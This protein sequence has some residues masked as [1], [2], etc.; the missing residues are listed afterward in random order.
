MG[1]VT[2]ERFIE[3][4]V[5]SGAD[6]V[7]LDLEDS[8][9]LNMK[10]EAR[11]VLPKAV[12]M[13]REGGSD[14]IVRINRPL[15]MAVPDMEAAV[16]PGVDALMLPKCGNP[17]HVR[18]LAEVVTELEN[19][20]RL[21]AGSVRFVVLIE[22]AAAFGQMESIA[23]ASPRVAAMSL[24]SEDF[25]ADIG[26]VPTADTLFMP[27]QQMI[28]AARAAGVVP[29]GHFGSILD[30][31][32]PE[33]FR[34]NMIRSKRFGF[35]GSSTISPKL[36]PIL[37]EVFSASEKELEAAKRIVDGYNEACQAGQGAIVIDGNMVDVPVVR[38]AERI[39]LRASRITQKKAVMP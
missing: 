10:T 34:D 20:A 8:V 36:V 3:R 27:K 30:Y 11:Q 25:A 5:I 38:R 37:N 17:D 18:L 12:K 31:K 23:K 7:I 4:A 2:N 1:P 35:E 13:I 19:E 15:R 29:L 6:V 16:I 39:L 22:T 9:P 14:V 26:T 28:I 32:D 24:G 33:A 21:E